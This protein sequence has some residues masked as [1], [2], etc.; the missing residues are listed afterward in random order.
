MTETTTL[1]SKGQATIPKAIRDRLNLRTG[2]R[3]AFIVD[4][5][6]RVVLMPATV[7][8]SELR[9]IMPK[10]KKVAT[11]DEMDAAI[12][13]GAAHRFKGTKK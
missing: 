4:D 8:V 7:H 1:T 13:A 11:L 6:G 9:G 3:L 5:D 10:P 12:Q 2:D